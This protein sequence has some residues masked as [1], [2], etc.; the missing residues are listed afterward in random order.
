[1]N[2]INVICPN[3]RR[4]VVKVTPSTQLHKILEEACLK[5]GFDISKHQLK[6]Q[7]HI[8]DLALPLRLTGLPNN[9]TVEMVQSIDVGSGIPVRIHIALQL[10]DG[11]RFMGEFSNKANLLD[12]L[13]EFSRKSAQELVKCTSGQVPCCAYMNKEYRG[14]AEL[15]LTTLEAMGITGG[16][17]LI[18]YF[19]MNMSQDEIS[20]LENRLAEESERRKKLEKVYET[21]KTENELR[22]QIENEREEIFERELR[23]KRETEA[24]YLLKHDQET[25]RNLENTLHTMPLLSGNLTLNASEHVAVSER[26]P[27][28]SS[29]LNQLQ[30]LLN[31]VNTSLATNTA[32][33]LAEQ[34][35]D[36][37]GR[38][39]ISDLQTAART[40]N[41]HQ[42]SNV[43]NSI[44][45]SSE[46]SYLTVGKCNRMPVIIR[47]DLESSENVR[48]AIG[49]RDDIDDQFFELTVNDIRSIRRDLRTEADIQEQRAFLPKSYINAKNTR[50]KE[51]SYKHTVVRFNC[52]DKTIIQAQFISRE[53]V[54]R[55]F[56]FVTEN[57]KNPMIKF[58]LCLANQRLPSTTSKN[59]IEVGV[60]PKSS[61]YIRFYSPENTFAAHFV[62]D[63][64]CE[65]PM[66][67]ADEL[68]R[69]WLSVNGIYQPYVPKVKNAEDV[70]LNGKRQSEATENAAGP[71][72]SK[73]RPLGSVPKWF[74]KL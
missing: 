33:S 49:M 1:M 56:E 41:D 9:A 21:R 68:S 51:E 50:L 40:Q 34:L 23:E 65:V 11:S 10:P 22:L 13:N 28:A 36:E 2:S 47:Q 62:Q 8:L 60:A 38:I 24:A 27:Q 39:H 52:I 3:S 5:Q 55:L 66:P 30:S 71:S 42:S 57:L 12:V 74:K 29:R 69:E 64:F 6:H 19:A 35:I 70:R 16:R 17:S 32:D 59:L 15:K 31:Q 4:C 45:S 54:S 7:N 73:Q 26:H 58:D 20:R 53:P 63:K 72:K 67:E 48:D 61:L 25:R 46:V 18:R 14:E 43:C 44:T 37:D